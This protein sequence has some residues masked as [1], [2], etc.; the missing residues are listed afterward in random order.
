MRCILFVSLLSLSGCY[1]PYYGYPYAAG[2][3]YPAY[4][5]GYAPPAYA[6]GPGYAPGY[7]YGP[8]PGAYGRP[9]GPPPGPAYSSYSDAP[10]LQHGIPGPVDPQNCGTPDSPHPC[11]G[12]AR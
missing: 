1:Y 4:G 10:Q 2:Y 7:A 9:P 6:P 5:P 3:P 8:P 11:A 12:L